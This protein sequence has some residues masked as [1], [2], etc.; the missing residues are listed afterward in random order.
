MVMQHTPGRLQELQEELEFILLDYQCFEALSPY[1]K[2]YF[3]WRGP[4]L[5]Q[6][7]QAYFDSKLDK[8]T[9]SR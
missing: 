8:E 9:V 2:D 1:E 3:L 5:I 6:E 7:V 4:Q